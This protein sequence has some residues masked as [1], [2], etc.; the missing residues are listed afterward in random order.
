[1]RVLHLPSE[2]EIDFCS[3]GKVGGC[4][5]SFFQ[6]SKATR[7]LG[8]KGAFFD[9][10]TFRAEGRTLEIKEKKERKEESEKE[11]EREKEGERKR[12]ED[13]CTYTYIY[14]YICR[15]KYK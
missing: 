7:E 10:C 8:A 2:S 12:V 11:R 15:Y 14:I 9:S 13:E 3:E 6:C 1:M 5:Q 4:G